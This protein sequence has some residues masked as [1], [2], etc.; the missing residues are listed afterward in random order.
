MERSNWGQKSGQEY[1]LAVHVKRSGWDEALSSGVLTSFEAS[2]YRNAQTWREQFEH[3]GVKH[4]PSYNEAL[5]PIPYSFARASF[6]LLHF[7]RRASLA[8]GG[9]HAAFLVTLQT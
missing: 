4:Q 7:W 6:R 5:H 1:I 3:E 8:L 9:L 2:A